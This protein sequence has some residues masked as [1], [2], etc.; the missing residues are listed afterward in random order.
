MSKKMLKNH[1]N[2]PPKFTLIFDI[3]NVLADRSA[4][5]EAYEH[6]TQR[7]GII[8]A[9]GTKH[10]L[11]P[12]I[13]ELFR[14]LYTKPYIQISFF[15]AAVTQRNVEFV[16]ALL[17]LVFAHDL[18][19]SERI[20]ATTIILSRPDLTSI[21]KEYAGIARRRYGI[22]GDEK[23]D[24]EKIL[25]QIPGSSIQNSII[26]DDNEGYVKIEHIH[27][28]LKSPSGK[29]Y[30]EST[31]PHA[32]NDLAF[33]IAH[34][35]SEC[36]TLFE[37]G[38]EVGNFL[39][40]LQFKLKTEQAHNYELN[41]CY[42]DDSAKPLYLQG[43]Q[44]LR[45]VNPTLTFM[46]DPHTVLPTKYLSKLQYE[47]EQH[48][49]SLSKLKWFF[50]DGH[51][52]LVHKTNPSSSDECAPQTD[53]FID[54]DLLFDEQ[55]EVDLGRQ[56]CLFLLRQGGLLRHKNTKGYVTEYQV[57]PGVREF[58]QSLFRHPNVKLGF[59][60]N[61]SKLVEIVVKK[62]LA[63]DN[64]AY[65]LALT[66]KLGL[67][68]SRE[69]LVA[70]LDTIS[71]ASLRHT[72]IVSQYPIYTLP[73]EVRVDVPGGHVPGARRGLSDKKFYEDNLLFYIAGILKNMLSE[74]KTRGYLSA[75]TKFIQYK[76]DL[77]QGSVEF[78]CE[79]YENISYY[80]T[81][82]SFLQQMNSKLVMVNS[83]NINSVTESPLSDE[84]EKLVG[85][86][87]IGRETPGYFGL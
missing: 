59:Y 12:G 63:L 39:F 84:E 85:W 8:I 73:R 25:C 4:P 31:S 17:N 18:N 70:R 47:F 55:F 30:S 24:V 48:N 66:N 86:E 32:S 75:A 81:G 21:S 19:Q 35:L 44:L 34:V 13:I 28:F 38:N 6:V 58:I 41:Y 22:E 9:A 46:L 71:R 37:R 72:I 49:Y 23:K 65:N 51:R 36:L 80:E 69:Q 3:D 14:W 29:M 45:T 50:E 76:Q 79:H 52:A 83:K 1:E 61:K 53:I 27:Q 68:E 20:L 33:Y 60:G 16:R 62:A 7:S 54:D 5:D 78:D 26:I 67:F 56:N 57:L 74:I 15:S 10:Y 11:F 40:N 2:Q 42:L 64:E 43:L 87:A 82:L 77:S